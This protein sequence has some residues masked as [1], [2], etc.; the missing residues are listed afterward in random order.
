MHMCIVEI[1]S[2]NDSNAYGM[3]THILSD[4][5]G[6]IMVNLLPYSGKS[7]DRKAVASFLNSASMSLSLSLMD[8]TQISATEKVKDKS[9][10]KYWTFEYK[11][12][13][14]LVAATVVDSVL[15]VMSA[16]ASSSR[17]WSKIHP[18]LR[19]AVSSFS[20]PE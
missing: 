15:Y 7:P 1:V 11:H 20:V 14:A 3:D 5:V 17:Q 9:N 12:P 18:L 6:E 13:N 8:A 4:G 10:N 19:Q 2:R 16:R